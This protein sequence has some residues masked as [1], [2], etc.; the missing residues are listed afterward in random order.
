MLRSQ[1]DHSY[2]LA[3]AQRITEIVCVQNSYNLVRRSD[4]VF[5]DALA[6]YGNGK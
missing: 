4:D 6:K 3:E 2:Q 1:K 5:I